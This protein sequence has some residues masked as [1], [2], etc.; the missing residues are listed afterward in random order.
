MLSYFEEKSRG[1][2]DNDEG[3]PRWVTKENGS[4]PAWRL[5]H[6][7]RLEKIEYIKAHN[8]PTDYTRNG[9]YKI[10]GSDI[11]KALN[12]NRS[13]LFNSSSFS[14]SLKQYLDEINTELEE[15]KNKVL[16]RAEKSKSRG[17]IRSSKDELVTK[18]AEL[19]SRVSELEELKVQELVSHV[20]DQLP[21]D[22]K[23]KLGIL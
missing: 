4:Y 2:N 6:D 7:M 20:F 9:T 5:I 10:R 12:M 8:R 14:N 19:K 23:R 15:F 1:E 17:T 18:N 11:A 21:L 16:A 13:S 22:I 3:L